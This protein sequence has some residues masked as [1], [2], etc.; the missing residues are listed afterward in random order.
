MSHFLTLSAFLGDGYIYEDFF[1]LYFQ[2]SNAT[3]DWMDSF[4]WRGKWDTDNFVEVLRELESLSFLQTCSRSTETLRFSLHSSLS[5][6]LKERVDETSR[7][8][9]MNEAI[10]ILK[11]FIDSPENK[12]SPAA[13]KMIT[14][15][16]IACIRNNLKYIKKENG[17]GFGMLLDDAVCF[18]R[19][20]FPQGRHDEA[21]DLSN[22][23]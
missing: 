13:E 12:N 3:P 1:R 7:Q 10:Q 5:S 15:H 16:M 11:C 19:F 8:S 18:A 17:L 14:S 22:E 20:L 9:Y 6:W 21:V 23:R 2:S 4:S